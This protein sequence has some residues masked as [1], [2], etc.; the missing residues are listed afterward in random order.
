MNL[1]IRLK[2]N[3]R[4]AVNVDG[5]MI[6]ANN[7]HKWTG[8]INDNTLLSTRRCKHNVIK[9]SKDGS[10]E[11]IFNTDE[12]RSVSVADLVNEVKVI[13]DKSGI[14]LSHGKRD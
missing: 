11:L 14:S 6:D 13:A 1:F 5:L 7:P 8:Q 12:V 9:P 2:S 4:Y 10:H 3:N